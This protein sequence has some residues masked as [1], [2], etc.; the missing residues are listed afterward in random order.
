MLQSIR[1]SLPVFGLHCKLGDSV[2]SLSVSETIGESSLQEM[3]VPTTHQLVHRY[4]L[5][6]VAKR[7]LL[8]INLTRVKKM[9]LIMYQIRHVFPSISSSISDLY[10]T[11]VLVVLIT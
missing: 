8:P 6:F 9:H 1:R 11:L 10:Y 7:H 2:C 3:R 4:L 5:S